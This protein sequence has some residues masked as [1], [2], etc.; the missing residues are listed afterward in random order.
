MARL[1]VLDIGW[2]EVR[3]VSPVADSSQEAAS[4][5]GGEG[6]SGETVVD[7]RPADAEDPRPRWHRWLS[8]TWKAL[9]PYGVASWRHPPRGA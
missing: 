5:V 8:A 7:M 4:A 9:R 2:W 1:V 3:S 6:V